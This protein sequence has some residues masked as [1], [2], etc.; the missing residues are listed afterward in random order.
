MIFGPRKVIASITF[1]NSC[2]IVTSK[3][4]GSDTSSTNQKVSLVSINGGNASYNLISKVGT[5][6]CSNAIFTP[7]KVTLLLKFK[8]KSL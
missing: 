1:I 5:T 3:V 7:I 4:I 6:D 2:S 8:T